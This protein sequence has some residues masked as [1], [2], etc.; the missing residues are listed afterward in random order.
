MTD[1]DREI[2]EAFYRQRMR[3]GGDVLKTP[4]SFARV[5]AERDAL[6]KWL[7]HPPS[8]DAKS[9]WLL[10]EEA[11]RIERAQEAR[12]ADLW[13]IAHRAALPTFAAIVVALW[14]AL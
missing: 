12:R 4:Q 1:N 9:P 8:P 6:I 10:R 14:W 11:Y 7:E 13:R 3:E 2:I 5:I